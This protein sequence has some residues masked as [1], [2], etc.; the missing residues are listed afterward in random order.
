MKSLFRLLLFSPVLLC[1]GIGIGAGV[2]VFRNHLQITAL[3]SGK[4]D[5]LE[6]AEKLLAEGKV[7]QASK[8]IEVA[9]LISAQSSA[10]DAT[11]IKLLEAALAVDGDH[12]DTWALLSFLHTRQSGEYTAASERALQ[13]SMAACLYCSKALLKWRF[14]YVLQHWDKVSEPTRMAAFSGADFLRWWHLEYEYL[15]RLRRQS[16]AEDIPFDSYREK[17]GTHVRPNEI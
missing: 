12:P 4:L 15:G 10:H 3:Q 17:V 1:L 5:A 14:T 8:W 11:A 2:D 6:E 16:L 7:S 9:N 13:A